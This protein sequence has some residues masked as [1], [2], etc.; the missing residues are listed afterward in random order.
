MFAAALVAKVV[1]AA[2]VVG[3]PIRPPFQ[4]VVPITGI[5]IAGPPEIV[6]DH[7]KDQQQG[8]NIPDAQVTAWKNRDGIVSLIVSSPEEYRMT[9]P[10][11]HEVKIDRSEIYSSAA[12]ALQIPQDDFNYEHWFTAPYTLD[13]INI[14]MLSHSEWYAC[15]LSGPAP[16][17]DCW[18]DPG[19][20]GIY[21]Y[22]SWVTTINSFVSRDGGAHWSANGGMGRDHVVLNLGYEWTGSEPLKA[23]IYHQYGDLT[24]MPSNTR[25]IK[26]GNYFYALG[27]VTYRDTAAMLS[28]EVTKQG[29]TIFRTPDISNPHRWEIWVEGST[30]GPITGA[31]LGVFT[32]QPADNPVNLAFGQIIFDI[33]SNQYILIM[34]PFGTGNTNQSSYY[35]TTP[36]LANPQWSAPVAVKG[37]ETFKNVPADSGPY[38][39]TYDDPNS[40]Y[41]RCNVGFNDASYL[42][43]LDAGSPGYNFEYADGNLEAY[44]VFNPALCGD[45]SQSDRDIYRVKLKI[46]YEHAQRVP[47]SLSPASPRPGTM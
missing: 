7:T 27:T 6:F 19:Q 3:G 29:L 41:Y 16:N 32:L 12:D 31:N 45:P 1:V 10:S 44:Y 25:V 37:S 2:T 39:G 34:A 13:G 35:I 23:L 5:E 22:N 36:S 42:S 9:G 40:P 28:G 21:F 24:G 33:N 20:T 43:L 17:G 47:Y 4:S 38:S 18:S 14:Y 11:L 46:N 26:E 15:L 30:Y 8:D